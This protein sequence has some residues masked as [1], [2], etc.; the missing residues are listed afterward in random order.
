MLT[1]YKYPLEVVPQQEISMPKGARALSVQQQDYRLCLWAIIDMD[2]RVPIAIKKIY[3]Y[4]TGHS[5]EGDQSLRYIS[6]V[7]IPPY[8]WHFFEEIK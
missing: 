8:V 6:T 1:I 2:I 3:C 7:Q 5:M 4:G